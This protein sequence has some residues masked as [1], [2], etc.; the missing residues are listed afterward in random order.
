MRPLL[1][2]A[3]LA[4]STSVHAQ[5]V[6]TA[7]TLTP[8]SWT[9]RDPLSLPGDNLPP[10]LAAVIA[11]PPPINPNATRPKPPLTPPLDLALRAAQAALAKCDADGYKVGVAISNS[12]GGMVVAIQSET[13]FPGRIYNAARKNLVAI[14][15]GTASSAVRDKLRGGDFAPLARVK[16]NMTL[17]PGAIPL[18]ADG[19]L[20]GAIGVSGAPGGERDEVCAAEGAI[21]LNGKVGK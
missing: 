20:I 8:P 12:L 13:A 14:E 9:P 19:K 3:V 18:Y 7:P 2:L 1:L 6:S 17:I 15:F 16:P 4:V 11:P 5:T 10:P 21:L